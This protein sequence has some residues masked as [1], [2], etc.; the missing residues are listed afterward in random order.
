MGEATSEPECFERAFELFK[1]QAEKDPEDDVVFAEWGVSLLNLQNLSMILPFQE[2]KRLVFREAED[3]LEWARRHGN[4]HASYHLACLHSLQGNLD[5][6]NRFLSRAEVMGALPPHEELIE[7]EW[8]ESW[9]RNPPFRSSR[10]AAQRK[11]EMIKRG[12]FLS[13]IPD[14]LGSAY[15]REEFTIINYF[16]LV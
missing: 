1:S 5:A 9:P 13:L 8:L 11:E 12:R 4:L 10:R 2:E 6:S 16:N 15:K 14:F 7:D 3:R